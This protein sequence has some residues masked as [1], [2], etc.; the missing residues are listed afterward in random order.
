MTYNYS[1]KRKLR[2]RQQ[3][4]WSKR[5]EVFRLINNGVG[6]TEVGKRLGMTK[7]AVHVMYNKVKKMT[8]QEVIDLQDNFAS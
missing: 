5:L 6:F 3:A 2:D 4:D 8:L 1:E 7:Q